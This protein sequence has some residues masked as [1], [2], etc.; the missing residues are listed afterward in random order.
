MKNNAELVNESITK[1]LE[2]QNHVP[3]L[4]KILNDKKA[5]I[6]VAESELMERL[7][8]IIRPQFFYAD[9]LEY[10]NEDIPNYEEIDISFIRYPSKEHKKINSIYLLCALRHVLL[11]ANPTKVVIASKEKYDSVVSRSFVSIC[12]QL[13]LSLEWYTGK[14][15]GVMISKKED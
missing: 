6:P 10:L 11:T 2:L 1:L 3:V 13:D 4:E 7:Q 12:N 14:H 5:E 15:A 8:A 9:F